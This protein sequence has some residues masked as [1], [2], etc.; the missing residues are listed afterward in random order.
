MNLSFVRASIVKRVV[1]GPVILSIAVHAVIAAVFVPALM[2]L[3]YFDGVFNT[4][5]RNEGVGERVTYVAPPASHANPIVDTASVVRA[6]SPAQ[7]VIESSLIGPVQVAVTSSDVAA[8]ATTGLAGGDPTDPGDV[9]LVPR[10][11]DPRIWN[12]RAAYTPPVR[13]HAETLEGSLGR[14][15]ARANDSVAA[16]GVQTVRPDWLVGREGRRF[17]IARDRIHL[18]KVELPAVAMGLAPIPGFGCMPTLF[19]PDRPVR[20]S[21]GIICMQLENSVLAERAER[22]N[23]MSAEIRARAPLAIVSREEIARIAM[24]K[25]RERAARLRTSQGAALPIPP[26]Q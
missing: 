25:D 2:V 12:A 17:G 3:R 16:L 18:G 11:T 7:R 13:S 20:D 5:S 22:I 26:N 10:S 6:R 4:A 8:G 21:A 1:S 14:G 19:F 9:V 23:E 24:R 15:I